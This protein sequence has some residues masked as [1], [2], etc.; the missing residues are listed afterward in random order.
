MASTTSDNVN[1]KVAS[2]RR[3]L[4]P[5]EAAKLI[6]AAGKRGRYPERDR[7]LVRLAYRHGLRASEAVRLR[8]DSFDLDGGTLTITR[9]KGGRTSTHTIARDDLSAL[10]KM[11]KATNGPWV[12]E[13]ER[14]GPLSVDAMQYIVREPGKLAG[15]GDELHPHM[16]RH[17]AGY[18]LIK[19][20]R[21]RAAGPGVPR[22]RQHH[23]HG[24]LHGDQSEAACG[25]E[26]SVTRISSMPPTCCAGS[27]ASRD[28][29]L[30]TKEK[31]HVLR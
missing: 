28:K 19:R 12:F 16:L 24:D 25:A 27:P 2:A 18:A 7:L 11:R 9:A 31:P 5:E 21:G 4:R 29:G 20:R 3:H 14:G 13:T 15:L 23:E 1:P 26:G 10:R 17:G 30:P 22:A 6:A 8:W